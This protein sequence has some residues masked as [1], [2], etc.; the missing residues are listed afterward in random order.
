MESS[1]VEVEENNERAAV[2]KTSVKPSSAGT[3][4][5]AACNTELTSPVLG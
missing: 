3:L 4:V 2:A 5:S 1:F